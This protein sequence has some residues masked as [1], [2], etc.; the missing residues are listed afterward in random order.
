MPSHVDVTLSWKKTQNA[1]TYVELLLQIFPPVVVMLE[2]GKPREL[3]TTGEVDKVPSLTGR[4]DPVGKNCPFKLLVSGALDAA[5]GTTSP[6]MEITGSIV[7]TDV[8]PFFETSTKANRE[9]PEP[10]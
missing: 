8:P 9:F 2:Q 1:V 10:L 7:V 3:K 5:V 4:V 6:G